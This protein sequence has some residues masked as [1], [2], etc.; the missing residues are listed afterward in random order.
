MRNVKHPSFRRSATEFGAARGAVA[1]LLVP[2]AGL[3]LLAGCQS[4][5]HTAG[6]KH[7]G[8]TGASVPP[9]TTAP[10]GDTTT[11]T[12]TTSTT[13]TTS[14]TGSNGSSPCL[15]G[16][17]VATGET[18]H[19]ASVGGA[20][21]TYVFNSN[22]T[23]TQSYNNSAMLVNRVWRGTASGTY[24]LS[25]STPSATSGTIDL[26]FVQGDVTINGQSFPL[27]PAT[28]NWSCDQSAAT[29]SVNTAAVVVTLKRQG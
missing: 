5:G 1:R 9:V 6:A 14:T 20:G 13:A 2:I 26:S 10:T 12:G 7:T 21:Q 27:E 22:G 15:V 3:C 17:W 4:S 29:L 24:S 23:A 16:S 25:P 19:G 8:T 11:T 28:F 18:E